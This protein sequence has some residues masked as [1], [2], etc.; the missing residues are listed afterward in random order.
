M[1]NAHAVGIDLGTTNS[2]AAYVDASGRTVMIRNAEAELLTPSVVLFN[3]AEVLVGREARRA[4]IVHPDQVAEWVKRDMGSP[5]YSRPIRGQYLPPE[6]IQACILRRLKADVTAELGSEVEAVITVPAYFDEPRR[7]ATA[8][9]GEMAGLKVLDIVNEPTAAAMA[10]G[11]IHGYL[12]RSGGPG[13]EMTLLVYDLGGGTFDVTLLRLA[14]GDIR[15]LATDG[16]VQLGGHDWDLRLVN[17]VAESFKQ[18]HG[19]DPREDAVGM[20]LLYKLAEEV[21]HTLSARTHVSV[22]FNYAGQSHALDIR[23]EQFEELTIDLLERT[24]YTTRQ[25][26]SESGLEWTDVTRVLLVGG[27]T[28]MPM[29]SRMLVEMTGI[30]PDH[31]V[32]PDEAVARGAALYASYVTAQRTGVPGEPA[33]Q[34]TNVNAHSLGVEGID[35]ATMRKMNVVLIR[36]N[37]QLPVRFTEKFIT[38]TENQRSIVVQVL[39]GENTIPG[40]CTAIGRAVIRDLPPGLPQGWPIEVTFEYGVNGRLSVH[41]IVPGTQSEVALDIER[42]VGISSEGMAGWHDAVDSAGEFSSFESLVDEVLR[43]A[44]PP[45][46]STPAEQAPAGGVG[47]GPQPDQ[48]APPPEPAVPSGQP[49]AVAGYAGQPAV[50]PSPVPQPPVPMSPVPMSPV[51]TGVDPTVDFQP[52]SPAYS[53]TDGQGPP[54]AAAGQPLVSHADAGVGQPL[55][56]IAG[57]EAPKRLIPRWLITVLG[58]VVSAIIGITVG[59]FLVAKLF[60]GRL[61]QLW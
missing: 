36:R 60:P 35:P 17:H 57:A 41:A 45:A 30:Q 12:A 53:P 24:A 46:P 54:M 13:K 15:A 27:A 7:K 6:V 20:S 18:A 26:L 40:E 16:D 61:P 44:V 1:A 37:S 50:S 59:Y 2:A 9:A 58:F 34:V 43:S 33:Y 14:P 47:P 19:V 3:D 21:K 56:P 55:P 32:N 10:F 29:V 42:E 25:L 31:S 38:K 5:A 11:E 22:S 23:R 48:T 4:S 8:D 39:E 28:R 49:V 51:P 52:V